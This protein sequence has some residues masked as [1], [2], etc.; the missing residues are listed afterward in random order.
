MLQCILAEWQLAR[1]RLVRSR[2]GLWLLLLVTGFVLGGRDRSVRA[3]VGLGR[4]QRCRRPPLPPC[5]RDQ[6]P[7][8]AGGRRCTWRRAREPHGRCGRGGLARRVALRTAGGRGLRRLAPR[9]EL[10]GGRRGR[11]RAR[12]RTADAAMSLLDARDVSRSFGAVHA[13]AGVSLTLVPGEIVGLVGPNGA[14]KTTLM[15]LLAGTLR[16]DGGTITVAG[17]GAGSLHARRALGFAPDGAV[18]P[19]T[20]TVREVLDY[21]ARFHAAGAGRRALVAEALDLG[22]LDEV[23]GRRAALLSRGY[24]QRLALAQAALGGRPILLLDETLAGLDP[25]VRRRQCDRLKALAGPRVA[26]LLSS[27]DLTA[28]ERLASPVLILA[29]GRVVREGSMAGLLRE[30][31]LEVVLDAPPREPPPGFRVTVFGLETELGSGTVEAALALCRAH[32]LAVRASRVRLK[33]LEDLVLDA[34]DDDTA[35]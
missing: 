29:R 17:H 7:R 23:A 5:I 6:R 15:R 24:V 13:M 20:L 27:H 4:G 14:G 9:R 26:V 1:T 21:Y 10:G 12:P 11:G 25:L 34:L 2:L 16:P 19:P 31:V 22:A 28:V 8:P 32:R 33:S 35:R 30:R 18:F 3:R